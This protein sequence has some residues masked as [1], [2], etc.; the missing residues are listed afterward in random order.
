MN[1]PDPDELLARVQ[2]EEQLKTRGKLRIFLGYAAGVGKTYAMLEAAQQ[3][4]AG[5]VD[6]VVAYVDTHGRAETEEVLR[7]LE[8]LPRKRVPYRGVT[9]TDLDLD[10]VLAR[11]PRLA[12]VDELAHTNTPGLRHPKRYMD[13]EEILAHGIDVYTT[14]NIQHLES[15]N[16]IVA[17]ITGVVVRETVPDSILDVA[18]EIELVDL[19]PD[20]LLQRLREGKVYI[21]ERAAQALHEFFRKGNLT[22]LRELA[23]RRAAVRVDE[24]MRD[25]MATRAIPGPWPAAERL[26]VC[27]GPGPLAERLVR[28]GR[29][30][31]D[32][33]NAEWF[34]LYVET[35]RHAGLSEAE[36]DRVARMLRMAEELGATTTRLPGNTIAETVTRYAQ[37]HNITKIL[38][39]EP[40]YPRWVEWLRGSVVADV[41]RGSGGIDVYVV[42]AEGREPV[43]PYPFRP[44]WTAPWQDYLKGA[45]MVGLATALGGLLRISLEPTNLVMLYLLVVLIAALRYGRG[46]ASLSAVLSVIAFDFFFVPPNYTFAVTDF[47]YLLTFAGLLIVG[48]V[49]STLASQARE[50]AKTARHRQSQ[51]AALHDLSRE[52]AATAGLDPILDVICRFVRQTFGQNAGVFLP[53]GGRLL[54]RASTAA[55]LFDEDEWAVAD[56]SYRN[57]QMAGRG[58][59]TLPAADAAYFPM[60]TANGIVGVIGVIPGESERD[61]LPDQRRLLESSIALAAL[62]IERAQLSEQASRVQFLQES[63]RLQAALLNSISHDL[64]TPLAS[65]TGALSSLEQDA[66]ILDEN[67]RRDLV[68]TALEQAERLNRLVGNLLDMTRLEAGTLKLVRVPNDVRDLVGV[69]LQ[70]LQGPL[71]SHPVVLDIP[72]DLPPV[73]MDLVLMSRV[74]VNVLDNAMKYSP[75]GSAIEIAARRQ[76]EGIERNRV[77]LEVRDRGIGIPAEDL[78]RVFDKFFRVQRPES[79]HGTGLG[80]SISRGF[81]EAHGGRI[82]AQTRPGGGTLV[83]ISLPTEGS[84]R[85]DHG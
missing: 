62:A 26:L 2:A 38:I 20:E 30:L 28:A 56:W 36:R 82:G 71:R 73:P 52:L 34:A 10:A 80:L 24:Q 85:R 70:E 81:V 44:R 19:P 22:A 4:L 76:L 40:L 59:E 31:A 15:F 63:E 50:Q 39:A 16:D 79:G 64:R 78:D 69:A 53:D 11:R 5:G 66:A 68:T 27:I 8:I 42:G 54:L 21:P 32:Q 48:L 45:L 9:L 60:T 83:T 61:L 51:T 47:Q 17:Q 65:I 13:V 75:D 1:R 77:V 29:R 35:H 74:L 55:G 72:A 18:A 12:L 57:R 37:L 6:V 46:P 43:N 14:L 3:R 23:M 41:I 33:L 7:G 49:V 58:S 84:A 25:Y 67:A